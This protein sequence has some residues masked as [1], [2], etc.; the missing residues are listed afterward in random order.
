MPIFEIFESNLWLKFLA[1][2]TLKS[3]VI[4]AVAGVLAFFLRRQSAALR[5]LVWSV[6]MAGCL[7]V[8]LCS[9]ALP[10]WDVGVLPSAAGGYEMDALPQGNPPAAAPV[11]ISPHSPGSDAASPA[12]ASPTPFPPQFAASESDATRAKILTARHWT[13]WVAAGWALA[14]LFLIVRLVAGIGAVRHISAR[15]DDF[16]DVIKNLHINLKRRCCV[17]RSGG[18]RGADGVGDLSPCNF[19]ARRCR[20]LGV[21]TVTCCFAARN[22]AHPTPRLADANNRTD[23]VCSILV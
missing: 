4:F 11:S 23:N 21:R 18:S 1:D 12:Q 10:K 9:L 15:S 20:R 19:V 8:P 17:R 2:A 14:A 22:G 5:G 16:N 13:D 6:A 3:V 7:I